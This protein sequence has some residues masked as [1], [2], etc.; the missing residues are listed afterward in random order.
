MQWCKNLINIIHKSTQ[1]KPRSQ[2][3]WCRVLF[4]TEKHLFIIYPHTIRDWM[5]WT[6]NKKLDVHLLFS[7]EDVVSMFSQK[8]SNFDS[9]TTEQFFTLTHHLNVWEKMAAFLDR[10]HIWLLLCLCSN[11]HDRV[12]PVVTAVL[13]VG[14]T[15]VQYWFS[16]WTLEHRN[17]SRLSESFHYI[18]Y[19]R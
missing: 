6:A 17:F 7:P 11:F 15:G 8:N 12:T 10:V 1:F 4:R 19:S 3:S 18:F 2:K 14:I 16:T 13:P 5:L 9:M